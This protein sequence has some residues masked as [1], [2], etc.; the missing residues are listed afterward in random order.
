MIEDTN[1]E[2]DDYDDEEGGDA[3]L[4]KAEESAVF[5][6]YTGVGNQSV[7]FKRSYNDLSHAHP[8]ESYQMR[9]IEEARAQVALE[10][11][12]KKSKKK[13]PGASESATNTQ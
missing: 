5:Y 3:D 4:Q 10:V 12:S 7:V 9:Q 2:Q 8:D 11:Q 13:S 1:T 6:V